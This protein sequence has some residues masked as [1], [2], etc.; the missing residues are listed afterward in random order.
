MQSF[1]KKTINQNTKTKKTHNRI[2]V[3]LPSSLER[4]GVVGVVVRLNPVPL[5]FLLPLLFCWCFNALAWFWCEILFICCDSILFFA[6]RFCYG[7]YL[8]Y[9]CVGLSIV[10]LDRFYLLELVVWWQI[11]WFVLGNVCVNLFYCLF[12][13]YYWVLYVAFVCF[14]GFVPGLYYLLCFGLVVFCCW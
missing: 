10:L 7:V 1:A 6:L 5:L 13:I 8:L 14:I 9:F 11:V 12:L 4:G 2:L 3:S